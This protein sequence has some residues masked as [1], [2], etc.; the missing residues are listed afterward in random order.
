MS[1]R[2]VEVQ[3][4][5]IVAAEGGFAVFL[6]NQEKTFV[7]FV[8]ETVGAAIEMSLRGVRKERPLTHDLLANILRELGTKIERVVISDLKSGT[9]YA[10][11]VL[12]VENELKQKKIMEIDARPS[13]SIAVA[14][15]QQAPIYVSLNVW[16]EL[17]DMTEAL[18]KLEAE[19]LPR[20]KNGG[21]GIS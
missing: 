10:R 14:I 17:E 15:A 16:E 6:G 20:Q 7:I 9:C 1:K 4:R 19:G 8:D 12:T 3:V 21:E 11:L 18:R 13:D 2:V 5:A